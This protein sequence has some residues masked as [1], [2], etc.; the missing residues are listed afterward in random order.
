MTLQPAVLQEPLGHRP[1]SQAPR[2]AQAW[3]RP[4]SPLSGS[5][6]ILWPRFI[7]LGEAGPAPNA[8]RPRGSRALG[9]LLGRLHSPPKGTWGPVTPGSPEGEPLPGVSSQVEDQRQLGVLLLRVGGDARHVL[10]G[11]E[12]HAL[13]RQAG[14]QVT[15]A[16]LAAGEHS[17]TADAV[18]WG[19]A[20][21]PPGPGLR[22]IGPVRH[23]LGLQYF[24][25]GGGG[26]SLKYFSPSSI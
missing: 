14:A 26:E 16:G 5:L 8:L 4:I 3:Q 21:L 20:C 24:L 1:A 9:A 22:A 18:L 13:E 2:A 15:R 6:L 19:G 7:S 17:K 10:P 25:G 12:I 23:P 11:A